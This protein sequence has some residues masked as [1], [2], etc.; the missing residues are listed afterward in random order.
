MNFDGPP[1]GPV[2]TQGLSHS[3]YSDAAEDGFD[4]QRDIVKEEIVRRQV[5]GGGFI[6]RFI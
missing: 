1:T 3:P 6:E 5:N 4:P 2:L